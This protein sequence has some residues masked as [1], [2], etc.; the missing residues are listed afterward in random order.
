MPGRTNLRD[1]IDCALERIAFRQM[2]V[3]AIYLTEAERAELDRLASTDWGSPVH[4]FQ[5]RGH[6]VRTGKASIIYSTHGVATA[7]PKRL[8][9]KVVA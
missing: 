4:T 7:I 2:D 6:Q 9:A 5:Y 1:R 3:R 8:S